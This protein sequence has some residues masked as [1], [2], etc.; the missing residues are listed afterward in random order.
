MVLSL[1]EMWV[2][3]AP[4]VGACLRGTSCTGRHANVEMLYSACACGRPHHMLN[5]EVDKLPEIDICFFWA[6][7]PCAGEL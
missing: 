5:D 1:F 2:L 4:L 6:R 7:G 3:L